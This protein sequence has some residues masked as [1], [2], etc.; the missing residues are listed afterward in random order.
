MKKCGIAQGKTG[1]ISNQRVFGTSLSLQIF[2][3]PFGTR[4]HRGDS[5]EQVRTSDTYAASLVFVRFVYVFHR[6][7]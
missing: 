4:F 5:T 3:I 7:L 1:Q 6:L 2:S